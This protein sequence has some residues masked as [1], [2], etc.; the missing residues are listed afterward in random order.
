MKL[1]KAWR[2]SRIP[3]GEVV[4]RSIAEER[5]RMWWGAFG[6]KHSGKE[7]QNNLELTKRALRIAKFDKLIVAVF[8]VVVSVAPF[9]S[10]F[11][12]AGISG[13]LSAVA[14][15][16]AATFG[17]TMLYAIQTFSSFVNAES[18]V[19]LSTLPI[20]QDDFSLITI[21][22]F[23]RSVDYMVIGSILSQVAVTAYLTLS[24]VATLVMLAASAVNAVLAVAA[25]LWF[26]KVFQSNLWRGGRSKTNTVLRLVFILM[27]GLLLVG[28]GFMFSIPWYIVPNLE[29]VVLGVSQITSMLLSLILPFSAGI[30]VGASVYFNVAFTTTL[31]AAAAFGGYMLLA[32]AAG[33]W[34]LKTVKIISREFGPKMA[35]VATEDFS[36]ETHGPLSAYVLKDLKVASRNPATAFFFALPVIEAAIITLLISNFETLRTSAVLVSTL[37]GGIFALLLPFAL[38]NA[39]GRG[40][41]YTKTLPLSS[42]QIIISKALVST[43]TY[44]PV[45]LALVGLSLVKPIT[46]FSALFIP[47]FII[48]AIASASIFEVKLFLGTVAK[49][50][51]V[52]VVN[53]LEK[54]FVGVL[55]VLLPELA[56]AALFLATLNHWFSLLAMGGTV[57]LEIAI[58]SYMLQR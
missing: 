24:L 51:I 45:P 3:Y 10:L 47:F 27:W 17:F 43:A 44:V 5:G 30:I 39:E 31:L 28:V 33:K 58:S 8:N 35:R 40:L 13:L 50:K 36:I 54:L 4:Y 46:S 49:G 1:S 12:G 42:R 14:L 56:Y 21:F 2:M 48:I 18:S 38:L 34:S 20:A 15:S 25:A 57:L 19:L 29:N 16:L 22:S 52:A 41:E 7:A 23:I 11:L 32:I 37:M 9:V 53:D 26:A 6:R 55:T